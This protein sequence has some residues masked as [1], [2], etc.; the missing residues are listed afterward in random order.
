MSAQHAS[1]VDRFLAE[2][3][4]YFT[5]VRRNYHGSKVDH[6]SMSSLRETGQS[7]CI[8]IRLL[9]DEKREAIDKYQKSGKYAQDFIQKKV[10]EIEAE[11]K[12]QFEELVGKFRIE[13]EKT[14]A[15]KKARL[16]NMVSAPPTQEQLNLLT[17]LQMRGKNISIGEIQRI[18]VNLADNYQAFI[19][20]KNIAD[21]LG[22]WLMVPEQ[23]DYDSIQKSISWSEKYLMDRVHDLSLPWKQMNAY[24][25][26]FFGTG[27]NDGMYEQNAIAILDGAKQMKTVIVKPKVLT[28]TEKATLDRLFENVGGDELESKVRGLAAESDSLKNLLALH[29]TYGS[30]LDTDDT[31]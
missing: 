29:P 31:K 2:Q 19:S 26:M 23:F 21:N 9:R 7:I 18:A 10:A 16:D 1:N 17:A 8:E 28:D 4:D 12:P 22:M 3:T 24:G 5:D 15:N 30:M 6:L 20:L 27:W 14:I 11:Y 13:V 25:R